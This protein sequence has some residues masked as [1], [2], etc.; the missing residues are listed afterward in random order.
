MNVPTFFAK[1]SPQD[2]YD[3]FM[4]LKH[5][6]SNTK[7]MAVLLHRLCGNY[8]DRLKSS[9]TDKFKQLKQWLFRSYRT[10]DIPQ[11]AYTT[12]WKSWTIFKETQEKRIATVEKY[13]DLAI[14]DLYP[15]EER[16]YVSATPISQPVYYLYKPEKITV[17]DVHKQ[18]DM[19]PPVMDTNGNPII[20]NAV[21]NDMIPLQSIFDYMFRNYCGG[22][23]SLPCEC[24]RQ[25]LSPDSLA[26]SL[27]CSH[28][29]HRSCL[30]YY[31]CPLCE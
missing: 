8:N 21:A 16:M 5:N 23:A 19:S 13:Y 27:Q 1:E 2:K 24:C 29:V 31:S 3:Y 11:V 9:F 7:V 28:L 14:M 25:P 30:E 4:A 6:I 18:E 22:I 15:D 17:E 10:E 20:P 12:L 26:L